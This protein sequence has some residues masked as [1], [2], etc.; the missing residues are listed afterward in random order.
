[1]RKFC[2]GLLC[3]LFV[4]ANLYSQDFS[5]K[6]KDFWVGYGYH[7][8]MRG[9][10]AQQMV[11][12]F[13]TDQVT[14]VTVSIPGLGY[15]QTYTNI[16]AN[17]VFTSNPLPKAGAQDA[18]LMTE[19]AGGQNKGIHIVSD[20]PIVA[21]AHIYNQSVSGASILFPTP[22]LGKEYYSINYTN[23]SNTGDSNC[24]FYVIACDTGTTTVEIIPSA[25]TLTHPA[26]VPFTV[27]LTQG[28]VYNVM[29][30]I[31]GG[32]TGVDLTG[33][34]VRSISTASGACKRIAVFSGSG[35][36]SITC[37]GG[38]SSSDN[39][40]VQSFPKNAWGKKYLTVPTGGALS[41]TIF[42]VCVSDPAAAVQL[43]GLPIPYPL[44]NNFYYEIPA[45]NF[46]HKIESD[47]PITVAQYFTS[48]AA[49]GN[50][51]SGDPEV[52]YLSPV[53]QNISDVL[54]NAT[55]NF[56]INSHYFGVVIPNTGTAISSFRIDGAPVSPTAFIPHPRDAGYS[57]LVQAVGAG[58]RRI[59]SDSGFNAIAYGFGAAESYGYNAGTNIRD[60]FQRVGVSSLY[61]I[62]TSP[63]VCTGSQFKFKVSLPYLADSI[64]WNL[65]GL[66]GSPANVL[67]DYSDPPVPA[68]ADSSTVVNGKTIYWYSLPTPYTFGTVGTFPVTI[69]VY[70][71]NSEGCGNEQLIDFE[72]EISN[73]PTAAFTWASS[74]CADQ[75][76]QFTDVTSSA[77][78]TYRWYW[79]FGDPASGAANTSN[80]QNPV[81]TFSGP[82]TY[83][84]RYA[85]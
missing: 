41:N 20:K 52:I 69:S 30:Q 48:Q 80:L 27:T 65:S 8:I 58:Q 4:S 17:T 59:Q 64:R 77:K 14:T 71:P 9:N 10:N 6:G 40:M 49:C 55:P 35:R 44:T 68:D 28:Q 66:P 1:M 3:L 63:S 34:R 51:N 60:L 13:A 62:E 11:L 22:T 5:N 45:S 72:L 47:I 85:N 50:A 31:F 42:R 74:G 61:G 81:H 67:M 57:Y 79:D 53:E 56:A 18:R 75:S 78:P 84:V 15:S 2:C 46:P 38:S 24:W 37:T 16:P 36:I 21:Y 39:Y 73:P 26:N 76:V 23:I 25:N 19:T 12:Y 33:S 29:G 70:A 7:Q 32:N 43:N 54:W 82:G 83:Q